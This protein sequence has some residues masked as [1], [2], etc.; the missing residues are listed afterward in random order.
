MDRDLDCPSSLGGH[1]Y[2]FVPDFRCGSK[3]EILSMSNAFPLFP[4]KRTSFERLRVHAL[5]VSVSGVGALARYYG[6]TATSRTAQPSPTWRPPEI[7]INH[8]GARICSATRRKV[9]GGTMTRT[10]SRRRFP[11]DGCSNH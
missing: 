2:L 9:H 1:F 7:S 11:S 3:A 10:K 8:I 5:G 6:A 4:R